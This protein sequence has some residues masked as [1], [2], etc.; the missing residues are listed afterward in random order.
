MG[1]G[2]Q[3]PIRLKHVHNHLRL[4]VAKF[5]SSHILNILHTLKRFAGNRH[6]NHNIVSRVTIKSGWKR[7]CICVA[8]H[9]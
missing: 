7:R 6:F 9:I 4:L 5:L 8:K 1:G 3:C 2:R